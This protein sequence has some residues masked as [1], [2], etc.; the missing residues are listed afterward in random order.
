MAQFRRKDRPDAVSIEVARQRFL[1]AYVLESPEVL[2]ELLETVLLSYE[3]N[4]PSPVYNLWSVVQ[5]SDPVL[6]H[7]LS[8]WAGKC[9]LTFGSEPA[10][11]AIDT[12]LETLRTWRDSIYY[13]RICLQWHHPIEMHVTFPAGDPTFYSVSTGVSEVQA[14]QDALSVRVSVGPWDRPRGETEEQFESRFRA[15]CDRVYHEHV[16]A[17]KKWT[18]RPQI[19]EMVYADGLAMWQAGRSHSEIHWRLDELHLH[20][21]GPDPKGPDHNSAIGKGLKR[22]ADKIQLDQRP[23]H[24]R[25]RTTPH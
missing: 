16:R 1:E 19:D 18:S 10:A 15:E 22:I 2:A 3:V 20:V 14:L 11:W 4:T 12:A 13:P 7:A 5:Y 21:G 6:S 17:A 24:N 8:D 23:R 9:R 25:K